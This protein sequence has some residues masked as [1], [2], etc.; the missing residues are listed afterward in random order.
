MNK[1]DCVSEKIS[2]RL[3]GLIIL[4]FA[5]ALGFIGALIVPVLG[6]FFAVPLL[7]LAG[8]FIV[9]PESKVCK[10]LLDKVS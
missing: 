1:S 8:G 4:P 7:V 9:A 5:L 2:S 6:L 3:V 10:L